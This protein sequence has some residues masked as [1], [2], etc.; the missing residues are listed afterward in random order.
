MQKT[1][2]EFLAESVGENLLKNKNWLKSQ[3]WVKQPDILQHGKYEQTVDGKKYV[4]AF[5]HSTTYVK[6]GRLRVPSKT[7]YQVRV[8]LWVD[9]RLEEE[10]GFGSWRGEGFREKDDAQREKAIRWA[11]SIGI[12]NF[13]KM[14][15]D[16]R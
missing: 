6:S 12:S 16:F 2:Q 9:G 5:R 14:S 10:K 15:F 13:T 1:L 3:N 8:Q 4:L 7:K 11:K